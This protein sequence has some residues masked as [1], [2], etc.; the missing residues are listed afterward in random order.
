M[1]DV[2]ETQ[3]PPSSIAAAQHSSLE[4]S[5]T[6]AAGTLAAS[7][8]PRYYAVAGAFLQDEATPK[9]EDEDDTPSFGCVKIPISES[10]LELAHVVFETIILHIC[11]LMTLLQ[12]RL[13][14]R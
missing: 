1:I 5:P 14:W 13:H 3:A 9:F 12:V 2:L 4:L 8:A 7:D 11:D 10:N 6:Q